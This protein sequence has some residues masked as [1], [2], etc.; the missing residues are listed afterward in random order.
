MPHQTFFKSDM[1]SRVGVAAEKKAAAEANWREIAQAVDARDGRQC[2][3]CDKRSDPGASGLL[4]RG[5][6][7]HLTYRSAGG[8]DDTSNLV[9]LCARCHD[10][11]HHSRLWITGPNPEWPVD[12]DGPLTF[13]R[14][15][16]DG[17]RY[18]EREEIAVRQVRKD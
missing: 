9:T 10:D 16:E 1:P 5:H 14:R 3:C 15:G 11:E 7:H 8:Q 18:I 12:A 2:R 6:R 4:T 17:T 13:W